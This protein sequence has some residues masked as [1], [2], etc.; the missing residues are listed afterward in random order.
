MEFSLHLSARSEALLSATEMGNLDEVKLSIKGGAIINAIDPDGRTALHIAAYL[1]HMKIVKY[2]LANGADVNAID[3]C[4]KCS[5]LNYATFNNDLKMIRLFTKS[6]ADME[7]SEWNGNMPIHTAVEKGYLEIVKYFLENGLDVDITNTKSK[8]T[9]LHM[10]ACKAY[11]E[12]VDYL[13]LNKANVR[14]KDDQNRSAI[15]YGVKGGNAKVVKILLEKGVDINAKD[16]FEWTPLY[17][18][19]RYGYL[20]IVH[21]LLKK[22]AVCNLQGRSQNDSL[23]HWACENGLLE[24]VKYFISRGV[25][26]D[27]G[28][29]QEYTLLHVAARFKQIEM[30]KYLIENGADVNKKT[31]PKGATPL[32]FAIKNMCPEVAEFLILNGADLKEADYTGKSILS[33]ALKDV[34]GDYEESE[35]SDNVVIAKLIIKYTVLIYNPTENF[36]Q[37]GC[38]FFKELSQYYNDCQKE[39]TSMKNVII[40]NSNVSL[41]Q[42][43]CD[44]NKGNAF[45]QYLR[46]DTIKKELQ[47]IEDCLK[48]FSIYGSIL[49]LVQ[50]WVKRG[51]QRIEL[52]SDAD[53]TMKK[54]APHLPS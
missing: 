19:C 51:F 21:L 53:I 13:L 54:I 38:P 41:Y 39:M 43:I 2:L 1:K 7:C 45:I 23:L 12:I 32:Y 17:L 18:A 14:L 27:F 25:D 47:N 35:Q 36:I 8:M 52:L 44:S 20:E 29:I 22:G 42:I 4:N 15:H 48:N 37:G 31:L 34:S 49:P 26:V 10:A 50:H 5:P 16:R 46:N 30:V 28:T 33:I 40:K 9:P 24:S 3:W 11:I 6:G